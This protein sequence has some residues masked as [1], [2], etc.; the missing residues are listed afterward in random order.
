VKI[1]KRKI[2]GLIWAVLVDKDSSDSGALLGPPDT[3]TDNKLREKLIERELY[4]APDLIGKR[5]VLAG[6]TSNVREVISA[7]QRAY[8]GEK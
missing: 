5:K 1:I 2:D 6:L 8:Y 3:L 7:Y 4:Q